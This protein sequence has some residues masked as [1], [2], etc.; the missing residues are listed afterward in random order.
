[1]SFLSKVIEKCVL[2]QLV[3]HLEQNDLFCRFQSAYRQYHSCE[4]AMA[5]ISNDILHSLDHNDSS[6][7]I[8]LDLS[9]AFDTVDHTILINRLKDDFNISGTVLQWFTSYLNGRGFRVKI[10]FSLSKGA[11]VLYGVPKGLYLAQYCFFY[12]FLRLKRLLLYTVL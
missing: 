2:K 1:M 9:A 11:I 12:T 8:L 10:N 4:T 6:F 7:L 5:K 3:S